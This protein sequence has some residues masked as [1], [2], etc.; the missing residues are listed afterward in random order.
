MSNS[1]LYHIEDGKKNGII[2]YSSKILL[3]FNNNVRI[4]NNSQTQQYL[5]SAILQNNMIRLHAVIADFDLSE[6]LL[7]EI[8]VVTTPVINWGYIIFIY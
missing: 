5:K 2:P 6:Q 8:V 7:F 4:L 1:I 3:F